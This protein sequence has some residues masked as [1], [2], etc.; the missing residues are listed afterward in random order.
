MNLLINLM[1]LFHSAMWEMAA[2]S[3]NRKIFYEMLRIQWVPGAFSSEVK[4][5]GRE[6]DHSP[7]FSAEVTTFSWGGT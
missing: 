2:C 1:Y 6:A 3:N 5:P 7:S 4:W